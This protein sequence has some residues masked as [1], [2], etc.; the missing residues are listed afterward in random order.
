MESASH[1]RVDGNLFLPQPVAYTCLGART[2]A[3]AAD[4][5][6]QDRV[7][8]QETG[9]TTAAGTPITACHL[10][11]TCSCEEA[12]SFT[13]DGMHYAEVI[14]VYLKPKQP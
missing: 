13:V 7:C 11:L 4:P 2:P 1:S 10:L 8:T 3:Q 6:L 5:I 14:F 9:V 12:T